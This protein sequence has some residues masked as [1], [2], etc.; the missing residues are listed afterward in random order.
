MKKLLLTTVTILTTLCASAQFMAL[1]TLNKVE[2]ID[3]IKPSTT[4]VYDGEV[5]PTTDTEDSWNITDKIGIGY[6]VNEKLMVGLTKDG[7][8]NYEILGRYTI[9]DAL[10]ATCIYNYEKDSEAEM[11]DNL[12][13]GIGYSLKVWKG[14]YIDPNYTLPLK[15]DEEG[16]REGSFNLSFSYKF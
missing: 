3:P 16:N 14:L 4:E 15:E 5:C 2:G 7:E 11:S 6:Q 10:W 12:D 13:V 9:K 8:D 1:S